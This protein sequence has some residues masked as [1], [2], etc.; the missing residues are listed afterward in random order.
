MTPFLLNFRIS[1][2]ILSSLRQALRTTTQ[3]TAFYYCPANPDSR[4][5]SL[6]KGTIKESHL[7]LSSLRQ[8]QR[9]TTQVT[10]F[11]YSPAN[12]DSRTLSLPKGTI[13]E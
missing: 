1:H 3:V 13:K 10:A 8:A 12:P 7:I 11:Y 4:T 5:L 2:L 9:T 6:P